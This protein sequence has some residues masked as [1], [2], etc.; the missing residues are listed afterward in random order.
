MDSHVVGVKEPPLIEQTIGQALTEAAGKFE[1]LEAVVSVH[2]VVRLTYGELNDRAEA[3]GA[4]LLSLGLVPGDRIGIWAPNCVEWTIVQFAT[5]KAGLILVNINPAY[6]LFELDYALNKVECRALILA[7]SFKTSR[8]FEMIQKLAPEIVSSEP[9]RLKSEKLPHLE[10]VIGFADSIPNGFID[11]SSLEGRASQSDKD[12]I[13][14]LEQSLSP[15]DPINI[16]FTSG[17]TGSPKGATLTH[18]NILNN[19]FFVGEA[20]RLTPDDRVAIP[21]PLYHCFGMVMGNLGALT[22]GAT[23]V[24]PSPVFEPAST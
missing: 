23:V 13:G 18:H 14:E 1:S 19:A 15:F 8:Y 24:Y 16:Q 9:G 6:R 7:E 2:Q 10:M 20:I 3:I 22:H 11:F 21:V 12:K 5:A 4:G 17:T